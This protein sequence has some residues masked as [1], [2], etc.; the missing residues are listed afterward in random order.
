[1]ALNLAPFVAVGATQN[2]A[3]GGAAGA[4]TVTLG[5]STTGL[6]LNSARITNAGTQTLFFSFIASSNTT[7][8]GVTNSTPLLSNTSGVFGTGGQPC[9]A[10]NAASTFTVTA[11]VTGG[12]SA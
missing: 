12:F 7:T 1:M 2:S 9:V 4:V 3:V 8:V 5:A 6:P 11:F 10:F